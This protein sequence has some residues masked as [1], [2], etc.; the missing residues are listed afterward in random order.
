MYNTAPAKDSS[1]SS[2]YVGSESVMNIYTINCNILRIMS[3]M[4]GLACS[5]YIIN[6]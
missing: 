5:N 6:N 3:G 4:R 1:Y 2:T